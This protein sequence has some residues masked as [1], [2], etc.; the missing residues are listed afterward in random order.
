MMALPP[1]DIL[2][3][4]TKSSWPPVPEYMRV[5]MESAHTW[6]VRSISVAELMDTTFGFLA[7]I[8]GSFV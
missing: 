3:P 8:Q 6:P 1:G 7:M 2:A 5:P 4:R